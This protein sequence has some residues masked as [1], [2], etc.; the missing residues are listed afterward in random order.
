MDVEGA[1]ALARRW[2][3]DRVDQAGRPYIEHVQR[4]VAAVE[5]D[6]EKM[7]AAL[8]DVMEDEDLTRADL[9]AAAVPPRVAVAVEHLTRRPDEPYDLY[10][11]RAVSDPVAAR[12]KA[13]DLADN[14]DE[15]RLALLPDD[16]A[17]RLRTKYAKA[18]QIL[19]RFPPLDALPDDTRGEVSYLE[20]GGLVAEPDLSVTFWC[21]ACHRPAGTIE[22]LGDQLSI[23]SFRG[24]TSGRAGAARRASIERA[25]REHD[26]AALWSDNLVDFWCSSCRD[27]YCGHHWRTEDVWADDH[28]LF[29]DAVYGTCPEGHRHKLWD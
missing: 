22:L 28:P 14:A 1:I 7:T 10:L 15:R 3:G 2:H 17:D 18:R 12:V 25:V 13:A 23:K 9:L 26:L 19:E 4:V 20:I 29:L 16:L 24:C 27:V 21:R 5:T 8:H 11:V 6:V